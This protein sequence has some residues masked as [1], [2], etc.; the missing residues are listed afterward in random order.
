MKDDVDK[1]VSRWQE[2]LNRHATELLTN[3]EDLY[4][5]ILEMLP[6]EAESEC[7]GDKDITAMKDVV[8]YVERKTI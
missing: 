6:T 8:E 1:H 3:E 5:R 2:L 4:D 7:A